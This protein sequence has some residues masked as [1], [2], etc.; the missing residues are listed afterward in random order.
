MILGNCL[1][2]EICCSLNKQTIPPNPLRRNLKLD[3]CK[4]YYLYYL[5]KT[6]SEMRGFLILTLGE[7]NLLFGLGIPF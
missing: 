5:L 7:K 3:S 1:S 2:T 4:Q 6:L